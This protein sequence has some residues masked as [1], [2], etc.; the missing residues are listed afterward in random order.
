[1]PSPTPPWLVCS[2][3]RPH[4]R[5][6]LVC[7]PYAGGGASA[8]RQWADDLGPEVE[9]WAVQLPGRERRFAE[10]AA[11]S[12][13]QV[14]PFV[15]AAIRAQIRPPWFMFG[16]SMGGLVGWETATRLRAV[17]P[18]ALFVSGAQAPHRP[19]AGDA[20]TFDDRELVAW[21]RTLGGLPAEILA[22]AALLDLLLPTI[23]ADLQLCGGYRH[24]PRPPLAVP[25]VAFAGTHDAVA[26]ADEMAAWA[27]YTDAGFRIVPVPGDRFFLNHSRRHVTSVIARWI[28]A[29]TSERRHDEEFATP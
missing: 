15:A 16:H 4:A 28:D 19:M 9:V 22:D 8:F 1:M 24:V 27:S 3:S 13:H 26:S 17:P 7:L 21:L 23:R 10:P 5:A 2:R 20:H 6:R 29:A 11:T 12:V 18:A 25:I 14:A